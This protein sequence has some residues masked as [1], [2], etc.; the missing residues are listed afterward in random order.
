MMTLSEMIYSMS[1]DCHIGSCREERL[2]DSRGREGLSV[3]VRGLSGGQG[4]DS[5]HRG[6]LAIDESRDCSST[7]RKNGKPT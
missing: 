2:R 5:A 7:A 1:V 4:W 6:R 3:G